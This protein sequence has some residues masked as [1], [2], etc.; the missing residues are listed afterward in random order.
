MPPATEVSG[1]AYASCHTC[2]WKFSREGDG[3]TVDLVRQQGRQ[4]AID[5][6]HAVVITVSMAIEF[7]YRV[8]R[9]TEPDCPS[10][11]ARCP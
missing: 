6:G 2:R 11:T 10:A 9:P 4:H 5:E 1:Y 7:D 3:I 8:E